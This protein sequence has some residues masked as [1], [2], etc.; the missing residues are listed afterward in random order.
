M[1]KP[2]HY[3]SGNVRQYTKSG[4]LIFCY[5]GVHVPKESTDR[6]S[7]NIEQV[8]CTKCKREHKKTQKEFYQL[9]Y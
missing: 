4:I 9:A 1:P 5:C 3:S 8:T 2:I 7:N 6:F